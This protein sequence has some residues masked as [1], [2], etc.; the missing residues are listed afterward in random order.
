MATE[1]NLEGG[2]Q[3]K[4]TSAKGEVRGFFNPLIYKITER[5]SQATKLD[6]KTQVVTK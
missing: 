6:S 3:C 5:T 4:E 1:K 2:K